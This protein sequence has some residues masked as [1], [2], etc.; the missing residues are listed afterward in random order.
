ME[1]GVLAMTKQYTS[2][3]RSIEMM[4]LEVNNY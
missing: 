3:G 4:R 1:L 2:K